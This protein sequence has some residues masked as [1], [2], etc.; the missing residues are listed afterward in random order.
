[1]AE[2]AEDL[3]AVIDDSSEEGMRIAWILG[4]LAGLRQDL[5]QFVDMD[6]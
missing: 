5:Q 3:Q 1:M 6:P 2:D 4:E